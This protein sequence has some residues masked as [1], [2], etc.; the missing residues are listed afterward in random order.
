[1]SFSSSVPPL[2]ADS[3][4]CL[5][6]S[7]WL[8][9]LSLPTAMALPAGWAGRNLIST[10][11]SIKCIWRWTDSLS[12]S[13]DRQFIPKIDANNG[14]ILQSFFY[15]VWGRTVGFWVFLNNF[16]GGGTSV[17]FK[18]RFVFF[19]YLQICFS[20]IFSLDCVSKKCKIIWLYGRLDVIIHLLII[21]CLGGYTV[22]CFFPNYS[23]GS[24][25]SK[26]PDM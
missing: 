1:M 19:F 7:L 22:S 11:L 12:V 2:H 8:W 21:Y 14:N 25:S 23:M 5:Q 18:M 3:F 6:A 4:N 13:G 17:N 9:V 10:P 24:Y 16:K 26:E 15:E 20:W